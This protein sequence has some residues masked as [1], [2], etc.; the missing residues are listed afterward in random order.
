MS[1]L[2][3][4]VRRMTTA[5]KMLITVRAALP[6]WMQVM[7]GVALVCTC[8]PGVPDFGLDEAIYLI[9]GTVLWL[10][11]RML[12]RAVWYAACLETPK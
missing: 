6:P 8:L 3:W 1:T 12:V 10:R 5:A 7:L 9:A 11:H 4:A 2:R